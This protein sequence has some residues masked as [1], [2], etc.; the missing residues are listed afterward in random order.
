[1]KKWVLA[2]LVSGL[3]FFNSSISDINTF[4]NCFKRSGA[5]LLKESLY[6]WT[7]IETP[8]SPEKAASRLYKELGLKASPIYTWENGMY[9]L[10]GETDKC[11]VVVKTRYTESKDNIYAYLEYSQHGDIMNI[12]NMRRSLKDAFSSYKGEVSFSVLIQG[13][14]NEKLSSDEMNNRAGMLLKASNA[15]YVDGVADGSLV[16]FCGFSKLL[17]DWEVRKVNGK[18]INLNIAL[19]ASETYGCT[20]I[21]IGYPIITIEY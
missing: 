5:E 16:S 7:E 2:I 19:R 8:D 3:A 17:P 18:E 13:R 9:C 4:N 15:S 6:A 14:Y 20:Y 12:N 10:A 1:M 11:Q 21:W